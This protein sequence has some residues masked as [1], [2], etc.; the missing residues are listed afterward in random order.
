METKV[1]RKDVF[2]NCSILF[3][4]KLYDEKDVLC[5]SQTVFLIVVIFWVGVKEQNTVE[6]VEKP[7]QKELR[8]IFEELK[9]EGTFS[10]VFDG[11]EA[12]EL[13]DKG[14]AFI[15]GELAKILLP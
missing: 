1:V 3:F 10:D 11:N 6:G 12:I 4:C 7:L 15:A 5:L 13:T 8:K 9:T 2:G 14:I